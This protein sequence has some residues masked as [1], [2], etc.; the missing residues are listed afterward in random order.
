MA[1]A[2]VSAAVYLFTQGHNVERD[3]TDA[4]F[5]IVIGLI[6]NIFRPLLVSKDTRMPDFSILITTLCGVKFME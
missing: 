3:I 5:V 6:D 1:I 2:C 4:V